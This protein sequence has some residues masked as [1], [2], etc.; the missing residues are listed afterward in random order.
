MKIRTLIL[1]MLSLG[2]S[3]YLLSHFVFIWQFGEYQITQPNII[4]LGT[5]LVFILG[6]LVFCFYCIVKQINVLNSTGR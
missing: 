1:A 5:A 6:T 4:L 3:I 2:M